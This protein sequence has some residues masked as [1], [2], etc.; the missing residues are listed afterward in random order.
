MPIAVMTISYYFKQHRWYGT[1]NKI[2]IACIN[3]TVSRRALYDSSL[4]SFRFVDLDI[5]KNLKNVIRVILM[6]SLAPFTFDYEYKHPLGNYCIPRGYK[7]KVCHTWS[8]GVIMQNSHYLIQWHVV[9]SNNDII[10]GNNYNYD[11]PQRDGKIA[12]KVVASM[13]TVLRK[14]SHRSTSRVLLVTLINSYR[15]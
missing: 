12:T 1:I 10:R 13:Y 7:W 15:D 11:N 3:T 5:L 4:K 8:R 6:N 2:A 9:T 14:L